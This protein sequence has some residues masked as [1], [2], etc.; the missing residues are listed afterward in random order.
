MTRKSIPE[1]GGLSEQMNRFMNE[2]CADLGRIIQQPIISK[3]GPDRRCF[4]LKQLN[5]IHVQ[6]RSVLCCAVQL[7]YNLQHPVFEPKNFYKSKNTG[8]S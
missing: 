3:N 6:I 5:A 8:L 2:F 4:F 1:C 7:V